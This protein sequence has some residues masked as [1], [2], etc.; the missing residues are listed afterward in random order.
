M[1]QLHL[2]DNC[3]AYSCVAYNRGLTAAE[4]CY[5]ATIYIMSTWMHVAHHDSGVM[6]TYVIIVD[7]HPLPCNS[8]NTFT[9]VMKL[10]RFVM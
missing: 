7:K 9:I 8:F 6:Y 4:N 2:S 10:G 1:V 5:W 3:I